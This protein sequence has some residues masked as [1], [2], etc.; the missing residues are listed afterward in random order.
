MVSF[1]RGST[2]FREA[3]FS[4]TPS[5]RFR[6]ALDLWETAVAL[7]RQ[8]LRR[9][10]P[11]LPEDQIDALVDQWLTTRPGAEK[12]D[13]PRTRRDVGFIAKR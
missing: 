5:G 7:R 13:G 1:Y 2:C 10:Y 9:Q 12:G 11:D 6:I 8:S 3:L 4:M